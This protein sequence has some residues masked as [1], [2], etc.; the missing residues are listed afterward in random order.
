MLSCKEAS[1]LVSQ[2]QERRLH[3]RERWLLR[4]HLWM[5]IS[6]SR[7]ERQLRL[8]RNAMAVLNARAEIGLSDY[9]MPEEVRDR[10]RKTLLHSDDA[11]GQSLH[12]N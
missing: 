9:D 5:C 6:C 1:Y 11:G 2:S 7:F 10:I 8:L 4:L 12:K 3:F